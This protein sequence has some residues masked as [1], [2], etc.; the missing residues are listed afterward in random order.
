M[1]GEEYN[2]EM[3]IIERVESAKVPEAACSSGLSHIVV[4]KMYRYKS[5]ETSEKSKP[6][7]HALAPWL[8]VEEEINDA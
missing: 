6:L 2:L 1:I 5:A 7:S 8:S 4:G 3:M